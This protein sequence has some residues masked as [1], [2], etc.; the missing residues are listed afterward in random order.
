MDI[1]KNNYSAEFY[2]ILNILHWEITQNTI[3]DI[4]PLLNEDGYF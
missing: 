3:S 4:L 2:D 1:C